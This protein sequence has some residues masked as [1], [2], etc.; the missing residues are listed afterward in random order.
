MSA[1]QIKQLIKKM[2]RSTQQLPK[3]EEAANKNST[4]EQKTAEKQLEKFLN[5]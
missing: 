1:W 3:I 5:S 4:K 2:K